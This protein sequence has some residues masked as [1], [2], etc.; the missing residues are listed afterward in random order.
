MWESEG[1]NG[2]FFLLHYCLY[3][4]QKTFLKIKDTAHKLWCEE[5]SKVRE[6]HDCFDHLIVFFEGKVAKIH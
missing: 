3:W 5:I 6:K 1:Q 4:G 2:D